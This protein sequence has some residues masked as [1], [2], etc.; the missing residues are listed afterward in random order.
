MILS[1]VS[2]DQNFKQKLWRL[3]SK[4]KLKFQTK[5]QNF[6]QKLCKVQT[7]ISI[8]NFKQNFTHNFKQKNKK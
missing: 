2:R 7:E 8:K 6:K 4:F 5:Y 1:G 3:G